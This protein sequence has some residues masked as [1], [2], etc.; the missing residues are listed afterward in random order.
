MRRSGTSW[1]FL[2]ASLLLAACGGGD[3]EATSPAQL[4]ALVPAAAPVEQSPGRS[5]TA[6]PEAAR[7]DT[8]AGIDGNGNG[9]RDDI[10]KLITG[11]DVAPDGHKAVLQLAR[12]T[13]VALTTST[14]EEA[15]RR[16]GAEMVRA[17]ACLASQL[18]DFTTYLSAVRAQALNTDLRRLAWQAF[19]DKIA[20]LE[21]SEMQGAICQ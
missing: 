5:A 17:Q 6:T 2:L 7:K 16:N 15:A 18:P 4:I 1:G 20:R 19:E 13:Q 9:I 3:I 21:F 12:A 14:S 8:L 11:F 10:D